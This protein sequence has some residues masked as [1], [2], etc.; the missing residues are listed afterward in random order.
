MFRLARMNIDMINFTSYENV[1]V[2]F[3]AYCRKTHGD[4]ITKV[5]VNTSI[6][7]KPFSLDFFK[8]YWNKIHVLAFNSRYM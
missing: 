6:S 4:M 3:K 8:K 5:V 7:R 2:S 1:Q